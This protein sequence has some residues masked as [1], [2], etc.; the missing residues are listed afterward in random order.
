[1]KMVTSKQMMRITFL[2]TIFVYLIH[3]GSA[4]IIDDAANA[5]D[6]M[7]DYVGG[8]F[9]PTKKYSTTINEYFHEGLGFEFRRSKYPIAN[10]ITRDVND[11]NV[12]GTVGGYCTFYDYARRSYVSG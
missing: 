11:T 6:D 9:N 3:F 4:N 10:Y 5:A 7:V 2:T 8:L 12:N 1:M